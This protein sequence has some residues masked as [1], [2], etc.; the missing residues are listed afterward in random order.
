MPAT[1]ICHPTEHRPLS[2]QEYKRIQQFPDDWIVCGRLVDQYRQIGNA[3]PVG[4]GEA[5]ARAILAHAAGKSQY[6]PP[7]FPFSR[8]RG[9]DEVSWAALLDQSAGKQVAGKV[10][11]RRRERDES[12][13]Q[14]LLF[15]TRDKV[16]A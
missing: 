11:S 7:E 1:D 15:D 5:V 2:V 3:V 8:Y 10:T 13:R 14:G 9:T 4:L 6:P 12:K 16:D